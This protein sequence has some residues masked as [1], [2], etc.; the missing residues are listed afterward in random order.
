VTRETEQHWCDGQQRGIRQMKPCMCLTRTSD[1]KQRRLKQ[2]L[3]FLKH[4]TYK[5]LCPI[6]RRCIVRYVLVLYFLQHST[7][8]YGIWE[9]KNIIVRHVVIS[10]FQMVC[11]IAGICFIRGWGQFE[12]IARAHICVG[13]H[14]HAI[15]IRMSSDRPPHSTRTSSDRQTWVRQHRLP[16]LHTPPTPTTRSWLWSLSSTVACFD[17]VTH[18][19]ASM[20]VVSV[21]T[22]CMFQ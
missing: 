20:N 17:N 8:A 18:M 4:R 5:W 22:L 3:L 15:A 6:P 14:A 21:R 12:A 1:W 2:I 19:T 9:N 10:Y 13:R 16:S 7:K 11:S